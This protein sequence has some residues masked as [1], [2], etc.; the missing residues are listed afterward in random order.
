[1]M[2]FM[3]DEKTFGAFIREKRQRKSISL[4]YLVEL[5]DLSPVHLSNIENNRRPAPKD[6]VLKKIIEVLQLNKQEQEEMYELAAKS[7]D[8]PTVPGD[9]PEYISGNE[10]ARVALR[11]AKDVDATDQEWKE[12][13][14]KLKKRSKQEE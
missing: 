8:I 10:L 2:T 5:L 13:I 7:K 14:E 1:M 4:R 11:T 6:E 3:K 12:F 9:L